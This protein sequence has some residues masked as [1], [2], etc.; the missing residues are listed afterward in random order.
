MTTAVNGMQDP[1][2][3]NRIIHCE[4]IRETNEAIVGSMR[5]A[6]L[7]DRMAATCHFCDE[8]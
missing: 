4:S 1:I 7:F 3:A 6:F 8:T 5:L 2:I